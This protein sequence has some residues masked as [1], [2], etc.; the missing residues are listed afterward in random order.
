MAAPLLATTKK[1]RKSARAGDSSPLDPAAWLKA[2]SVAIAEDGFNGIRI[3]PL[4]KRLGVTRGSFYWHF[5]SHAV[6]VRAFVNHWQDIQLRAV[7]AFRHDAN[8][9]VTAY[10]ELLDIVLTNTGAEL[11]R[12]KVEFAL[13]GFARRDKFAAKAVALVDRARTDLFIPI[14]REIAR[15]DEEA[16]A[17]A[18]LLL[19]QLSGA[20]HAI[21]GP[22]FDSVML[23]RLK[24]AMLHS[25]VAL[26]ETRAAPPPTATRSGIAKLGR[27]L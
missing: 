7:A 25:L 12:L 13:R 1:I 27:S 4:S 15:T 16:E 23:A 2:A 5:A 17:F 14:V 26:Y 3:L 19:V 24:Q 10:R 18:H 6:F 9:A 11:K 8:D 20:Q 22:N 21:A